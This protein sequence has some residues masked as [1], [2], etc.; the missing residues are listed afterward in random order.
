MFMVAGLV[1]AWTVEGV[2]S[3]SGSDNRSSQAVARTSTTPAASRAGTNANSNAP[4]QSDAAATSHGSPQRSTGNGSA[5]AV[6]GSAG[7]VNGNGNTPNGNKGHIQIE[8]APD[9]GPTPCGNDNDPHVCTLT[10]QL[11]GYPSGTNSAVLTITGQAPSGTGNVLSD[12]FTFSPGTS[13][14]NGS[15][16]D[17]QKSY[18]LSSS[19]LAA[20]GLTPQPQQGY[21]LRIEVAVNGHPAKTHVVWFQPC[22]TAPVLPGSS[23]GALMPGDTTTA[24]IGLTGGPRLLGRTA[25]VRA[26]SSAPDTPVADSA[27]VAS[28]APDS[29]AF[30]TA[31]DTTAALATASPAH[32]ARSHGS[33][34]LAFTGA[35]ILMMLG[36]AATALAIGMT[37][38][39]MSRRR[40]SRPVTV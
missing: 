18:D 29:L 14:P 26:A 11:F 30:D 6:N 31:P 24:N 16:L 9:C 38:V 21:H 34:I 40:R 33:G 10:V 37:L 13:S 25:A 35:E 23:A 4:T 5:G 8:G 20:D 28:A 27:P 36:G 3:A 7:A 12:S 39:S 2:A 15:V 1:L 17:T 19:Q 22:T 32:H